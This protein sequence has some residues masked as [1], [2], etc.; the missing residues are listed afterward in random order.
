MLNLSLFC[1]AKPAL[2]AVPR[3]AGVDHKNN[4][5]SLRAPSS[6]RAIRQILTP[7]VISFAFCREQLTPGITRPGRRAP[8]T[9]FDQWRTV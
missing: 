2:F 5:N 9:R 8:L 7:L 3:D 4:I 1:V 6:K